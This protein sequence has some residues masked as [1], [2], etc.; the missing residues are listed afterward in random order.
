MSDV[1]SSMI[2]RQAA[3]IL[4]P[5]LDDG[6]VLVWAQ[7][8]NFLQMAASSVRDFLLS[9]GHLMG[10]AALAAGAAW[11][12]LAPPPNPL[13]AVVIIFTLASPL[14]VDLIAY[15]LII[16]PFFTPRA[17]G[18]TRAY[19]LVRRGLVV[20]R[21]L[22]APVSLISDISLMRWAGRDAICFETDPQHQPGFAFLHASNP[23]AALQQ[24]KSAIVLNQGQEQTS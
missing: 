9:P 19:I 11:T 10:I 7:R 20:P 15:P 17:Y 5:M 6:E 8:P 14:L 2:D 24:L 22:R 12:R 4:Q 1:G 23:S 16:F 13:F 3:A 21:L 18:A